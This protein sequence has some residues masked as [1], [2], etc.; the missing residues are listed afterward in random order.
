MPNNPEVRINQ[1]KTFLISGFFNLVFE[2]ILNK[3]II[4]NIEVKLM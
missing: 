2:L 4:G 3:T 1:D